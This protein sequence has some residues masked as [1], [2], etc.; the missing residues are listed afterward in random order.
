MKQAKRIFLIALAFT[1]VLSAPSCGKEENETQETKTEE[2]QTVT[3]LSTEEAA[4]ADEEFL[5]QFLADY[6]N[7]KYEDKK[8][9]LYE[10]FSAYVEL[11]P[12]TN[13]TYPDDPLLD[14]TVTDEEVEAFVTQIFLTSEV[15][16]DEYTELTEGVVQK[17]DVV[18]LDYRGV[19]D[20]E[21]EENA[22]AQDQ[23]LLI[24]SGTYISGFE[25]GL[26]GKNIGEEVVLNLAFSPYYN[27]EDVAGKP[28]VFYVTVKKVERPAIPE[29][30][31][32]VI[33]KV[34]ETEFASMDEA[35]AWIKEALTLQA[36]SE[37]Y[38]CLASYLQ[39]HVVKAST[40]K[41]YP[42]REMEH[43]RNHYIAYY[44]QYLSDGQ[45]LEAFCAE[46]L[47]ITYEEFLLNAEEYAKEEIKIKLVIGSIAR[48]ENITC[49]D[50]QLR[51]CITG[52][53]ASDDSGVYGS[54]K[55]MVVDYTDI[56]G[57]DYFENQ[58]ISAAV[59]EF[60]NASAV[61]EAA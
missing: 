28:V 53:Y 33:N 42:E 43:Y 23:S 49:S 39:K 17:Y 38:S 55:S 1:M 24:G 25:E 44:S 4:K 14:E 30:T 61:K 48:N 35:R 59:M 40:V 41:E 6:R 10:D 19:I 13:L 47:G 27:A 3:E 5:D 8:Y 46:S 20:G 57:A 7:G 32:D 37:A 56:Y 50:E 16:D 18:T 60:V 31:V 29:F 21:E 22:T 12:Y 11:A 9:F 15:S 58:V 54:L 51:S 34:Y 26:I 52:L 2:T 36:E 45:T